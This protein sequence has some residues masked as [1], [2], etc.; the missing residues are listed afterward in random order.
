MRSSSSS[1]SVPVKRDFTLSY[2]LSLVVAILMAVVSAAG[3]MRGSAGLYGADPK[4]A[5][6]V[7]EAEAGMLMSG[8]LGQDASNLVVVVPLLL[9]S[10]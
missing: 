8:L 10:M 1:A 4:R 7:R 6:G 2:A 9:G 5:L 3:L